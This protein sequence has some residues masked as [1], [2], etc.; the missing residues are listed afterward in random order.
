MR[1]RKTLGNGYA[2]TA[3]LGKDNIMNKA[4][5]TFI[6]STFWTERIGPTAALKTIQYMKKHKTWIKINQTA[7]KFRNLWSFLAK[8]HNLKIVISG[9]HP[10]SSFNFKS[11]NNQSIK[12]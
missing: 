7:K 10:L 8:K 5:N 9:I 1:I 11:K 4:N 2:I 6:S 12:L 3:V